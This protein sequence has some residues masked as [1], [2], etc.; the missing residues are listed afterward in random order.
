[1]NV[2]NSQNAFPLNLN[3]FTLKNHLVSNLNMNV[4]KSQATIALRILVT[5]ALLLSQFTNV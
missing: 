4:F 1:M 5:N 2:A 3:T